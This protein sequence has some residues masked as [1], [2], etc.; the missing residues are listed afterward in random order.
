MGDVQGQLDVIRSVYHGANTRERYVHGMYAFA[1]VETEQYEQA[2]IVRE[3]EL[4][5]N[6]REGEILLN[7]TTLCYCSTA[8]K[9]SHWATIHGRNMPCVTCTIARDRSIAAPRGWRATRTRGANATASCTRTT[10]GTWRCSISIE[11]SRPMC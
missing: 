2:E 4:V 3:L 1:L 8:R 9:V 5:G 7:T 6:H 10:G 11:S